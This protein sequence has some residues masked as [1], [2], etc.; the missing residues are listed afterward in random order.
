MTAAVTGA[1]R[2]CGLRGSRAG[3][4]SSVGAASSEQAFERLERLYGQ[5]PAMEAKG[6]ALARA[7]SAAEVDRFART[8]AYR[9]A[10]LDRAEAQ[11]AEAK[12]RVAAAGSQ[13][14][15]GAEGACGSR[16]GG[17]AG[18]DGTGGAGEAG[19]VGSRAAESAAA[20]Q[21]GGDT[22]VE[23]ARRA[24]MAAGTWRGLRVGPARN[25]ERALALALEASP[26]ATVEEARAA[27]LPSDALAA[28]AAEVEAYQRDYAE[29]L[30]ACQQLE[31]AA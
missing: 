18:A 29:A 31:G 30:A 25:A 9:A 11:V 1:E 8:A 24:L 15:G 4:D 28:L 7:R 5:L 23:D 21:A 22:A 2:A 3:A 19:T 20:S 10:E 17:G 27:L 14:G 26:F 16:V 13:V 12:A 6:A